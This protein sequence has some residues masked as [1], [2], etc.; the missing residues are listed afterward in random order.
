MS[1]DNAVF[2]QKRGDKYY[3]WEGG[4]SYYGEGLIGADDR[5]PPDNAFTTEDREHAIGVADQMEIDLGYVEYGLVEL[6]EFDGLTV[7]RR[8][9]D[10][11]G[12]MVR[13]NDGLLTVTKTGGN[14]VRWTG[15]LIEM[16]GHFET[17]EIDAISWWVK[18][19]KIDG[20]L[21]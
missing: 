20:T 21:S 12:L 11:L 1:A 2:I 15:G 13:E 3:V 19:K 7:E 17:F 10:V 8:V 18:N 16:D 6:P 4:M 14:Y 9:R 5:P